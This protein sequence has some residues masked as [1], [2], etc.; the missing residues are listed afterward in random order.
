MKIHY[1][2]REK[3]AQVKRCVELFRQNHFNM[4]MK[5]SVQ[6]GTF[7]MCMW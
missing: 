6:Q 1:T 3:Q 2:T 7:V 5:A 4:Q